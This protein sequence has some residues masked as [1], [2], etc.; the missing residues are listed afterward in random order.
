MS[1][2]KFQKV[3]QSPTTQ[4]RERKSHIS[5]EIFLNITIKQKV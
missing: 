3:S 1:K 4:K 5:K 2:T